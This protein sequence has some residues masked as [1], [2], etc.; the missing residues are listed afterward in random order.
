MV[1]KYL[2][3]LWFI[4]CF[5]LTGCIKEEKYIA[6]PTVQYMITPQIKDYIS[7]GEPNIKK[8]PYAPFTL[9][10]EG[11]FYI[12]DDTI[13][14]RMNI[15]KYNSQGNYIT[16]WI[17]EIKKRKKNCW[18]L[19]RKHP[20]SEQLTDILADKENIYIAYGAAYNINFKEGNFPSDCISHIEQFDLNGKFIIAIKP[21][22]DSFH[23][24]FI[25]YIT[26][27]KNGNF[28]LASDIHVEKYNANWKLQSILNPFDPEKSKLQPGVLIGDVAADSQGYIY[29]LLTSPDYYE[30]GYVAKFD[31]F[32]KLVNKWNSEDKDKLIF[33]GL[34][35]DADDNI[36]LLGID[37]KDTYH[38]Q[39]F[40]SNGIFITEWNTE[41]TGE[42]CFNPYNDMRI[43][44]KGN[45]YVASVKCTI[46][47]F[48]PKQ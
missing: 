17:P 10:P 11:N 37:R 9:D 34:E 46:K 26:K 47:K 48:S 21:A 43:D 14:S 7:T 15:E 1:D 42:L 20:I 2:L 36:Y 31:S 6:T 3:I 18:F 41:C 19:E 44:C 35:I 22:Y 45:I 29:I 16:G 24:Y 30:N 32:G 4:L 25:R 40:Y 8:S 28:Y 13:D 33:C 12:A 23:T 39:K 38:I 5:I 27:D